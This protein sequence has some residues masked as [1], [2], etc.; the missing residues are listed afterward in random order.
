MDSVI[1]GLVVLGFMFLGVTMLLLTSG[2]V[3]RARDERIARQIA[4]TDA[5]HR[6]VGPVVAPWVYRRG[7][8]WE[9]QMAVP[10]ERP[11]LVEQIL[12]VTRQALAASVPDQGAVRL[13]LTPQPPRPSRPSRPARVLGVSASAA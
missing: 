6:E 2:R 8:G 4:L 7:R 13:V 3:A 5:L 9:V 12:D 10:F 11:A 1:S